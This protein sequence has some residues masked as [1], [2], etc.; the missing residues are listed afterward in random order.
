MRLPIPAFVLL[1]LLSAPAQARPGWDTAALETVPVQ[2]GGRK[3]PFSTFTT[4]TLQTLSGRVSYTPLRQAGVEAGHWNAQQSVLALWLTPDLWADE[5]LILVNYRP[6]VEAMGLDPA[7]KRFAHRAI[8]E[9]PAFRDLIAKAQVSRREAP[10][11]RLPRLQQEAVAVTKRLA[12]LDAIRDGSHFAF[13]PNP[14][15]GGSRWLSATQAAQFFPGEKGEAVR[16]AFDTLQSSY[17]SEDRAAFDVAAADFAQ[18]LATLAPELYPPEKLLKLEHFYYG[19]HPFRLAWICYALAGIVLLTTSLWARNAGYKL[20]WIFAGGGFV[21]QGFGFVCRGLISGRAPVTNMYESLIWVAFGTVL[22]ALVFEA[23]YRSRIFLLSATPLAVL[24]LILA[25]SQP[26]VLD[27]GIHPLVPV[28]RDNFWL[29][30]HVLTITLSY[31][32]FLLAFGVAHGILGG[33]I[34]GRKP[35]G[36]LHTYLYRCLQIGVLLL[37]IGTILGGVWANYSWG[38]F[39]DWDPKETWAL[40]A[41]LCYIFLLHGRVAGYWGAFGLAVGSVVGF[42]AVVMA[43][44]GVNFVLGAGLHSYGFG[45]GGFPVVLGLVTLELAF[46]AT[47]IVRHRFNLRRV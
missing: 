43:W 28:L 10:N 4:E 34:A 35:S 3:K 24:S 29:T 31:A 18:A 11:A 45:T 17:R 38:R 6:L 14:Q 32:A 25:D 21:L 8:V 15:G 33:A 2:E 37:G 36:A 22:F 9:N 44:Y 27:S 40:I 39:W 47:A 16:A 5:P 26:T 12:H 19:L 42:L 20:G 13:V 46:T 30:T 41:F 7:K 1:C 23:I